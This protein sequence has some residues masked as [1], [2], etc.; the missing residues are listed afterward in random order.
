MIDE[1]L[2]GFE[3][4]Q[5]SFVCILLYLAG[6]KFSSEDLYKYV[7]HNDINIRDTF[8]SMTLEQKSKAFAMISEAL[9][10]LPEG[11]CNI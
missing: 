4:D 2:K 8:K 9:G 7:Q 1:K 11:A 10:Y 3:K 6:Y 5:K